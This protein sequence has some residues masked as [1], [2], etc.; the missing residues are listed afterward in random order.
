MQEYFF[1]S[2]YDSLREP[3]KSIKASSF[4]EA[5]N[6]FLQLKQLNLESFT[7]IFNIDTKETIVA[8]LSSF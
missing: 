6:H 7:Q 4:A 3:I 8:T 2:K 5:L 1:Y